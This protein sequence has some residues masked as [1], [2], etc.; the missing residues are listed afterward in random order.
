MKNLLFGIGFVV[1]TVWTHSSSAFIPPV[2]DILREVTAGRKSG[3]VEVLLKHRISVKGSSVVEV[4][5]RVIRERDKLYFVW[6][7]ASLGQ[8]LSAVWER[9][10]YRM[11]NR[12]IP[13]RSKAMMNALTATG[14][15]D[16]REV[17]IAE[18]F[19]RRENLYQF[20]PGYSPTGEPQSWE[21][22]ENYL[23]HPNIFLQKLSSGIAIVMVGQEEGSNRKAVY[24]DRSLKGIR[25]L[26]WQENQETFAWN[27]DGFAA[28]A[29]G[30]VHPRRL[31]LE[32]NGAEVIQSDTLAVR[33]ASARS[34]ADFKSAWRQ[35]QKNEI[36]SQAEGI[37]KLM[38]SYR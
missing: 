22:R 27:F 21:T 33:L 32:A 12:T 10:E 28:F 16:L 31:F 23:A 9:Y 17:L 26:E 14:P 35:A 6:S 20:K 29:A 36:S 24:F 11:G 25:K 38:L 15:E 3:P 30:G 18:Q 13:S 1:F 34:V 5:E 2:L 37:L 8:T 19:I 4:D 7:G